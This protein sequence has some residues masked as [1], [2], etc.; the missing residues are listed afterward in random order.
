MG[1]ACIVAAG[2][3]G[4]P[5]QFPASTP[6]VLAVSAIGKWGEFPP[7]SFHGTQAVDGFASA[8]GYFPAKFSCF[9][10]EVDVCAPGVAIISALPSD[11][12][13]AWDGTSM[14]APHVTGMAALILAHH[15]DFQGPYQARDARRVEQLF[16]IIKPSA[17]PISFG[18]PNRTGAGLPNV[19]RALALDVQPAQPLAAA[20][21][22]PLGP[23]AV[24]VFRQLLQALSPPSRDGSVGLDGRG[25]AA[26]VDAEALWRNAPVARGRRKPPARSRPNHWVSSRRM[27]SPVTP[28][29]P[30]HS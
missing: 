8:D 15:P 23:E 24:A 26:R 2:N 9:G 4:G 16:T 27:C 10:P 21:G 11:G 19:A 7:A 28:A 12:F 1:T 5:V 18:D 30:I 17:T 25:L 6:H 13:G 3:S 20:N 22:L 29:P 14:A